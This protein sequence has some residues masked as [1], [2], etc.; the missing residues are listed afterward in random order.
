MAALTEMH[1][2]LCR[3]INMEPDAQEGQ[4][5][6]HLLM[7]PRP[8]SLPTNPIVLTLISTYLL[9]ALIIHTRLGTITINA[10]ALTLNSP[11]STSL[12]AWV[13]SLT[14]L[15]TKH[16][17]SLLTR[18]YTSLIKL[19]SSPVPNPKRHPKS[20]SAVDA[21][22]ELIFILRMYALRCLVHTSPGTVETNMVWDQVV[23]FTST[24]VKVTASDVALEERCTAVVL[25]AYADLVECGEKRPDRDNFM[26][27]DQK[28]KGFLGFCENWMEFTKRVSTSFVFRT[29]SCVFC[30]QA[31][32][33]CVLQKI[34]RLMR[35]SS[36]PSCPQGPISE[37][38][39]SSISHVSDLRRK[40]LEASN[41][42]NIFAQATALLD[43][44]ST[45]NGISPAM[46]NVSFPSKYSQYSR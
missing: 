5:T 39:E 16:M 8:P 22:P 12:L 9:H 29:I 19:A 21:S 17:D 3:L 34:N 20:T 23:R 6:L 31:G 35:L 33:I 44:E 45:R 14:S 4:T 1:P 28:G 13:P 43:D 37:D 24:F 42:C 30:Y 36:S 18:A 11:R 46:Q 10:L 40:T 7:V 2:A 41:F 26:A 25:S 32:D 38:S 27:I 15:P